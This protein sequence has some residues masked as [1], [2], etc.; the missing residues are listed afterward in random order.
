MLQRY[1]QTDIA[2]I[3]IFSRDE[4]KQDDMRRR[5]SRPRRLKFYIGDVRNEQS[6]QDAMRGV[7]Y[8]LS[9]RRAEAGAVVRVLSDGG[10]AH[11][12]ARR[13][14]RAQR[15]DRARRRARHRALDRQGRLSDQR[16]GHLEGA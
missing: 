15:G 6:R 4:K 13:R 12:R 7:D 16:H 8:R 2:E 1:L 3:R 5:W 10:G 11:Q 9:R 14:E